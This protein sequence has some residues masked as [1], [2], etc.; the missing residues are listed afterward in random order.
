MA[1]YESLKSAIKQVVKTNGN[2]E[3]TGALLQQSLLAMINS[4]GNGYQFVGIANPATNPGTPDARSYYMAMENGIYTNF[5]ALSINNE[6]GLFVYDGEWRKIS[7]DIVTASKLEQ[8][9]AGIQPINNYGTINNA[10][11]NEDIT[12]VDSLL[13][14]K[15]RA[16]VNCMGYVILRKDKTF[17]QQVTTANT[18]Y[19]IRYDFNLGTANIEMPANCILKFNGGKLNGGTIVGDNTV[20]FSPVSKCF[21]LSTILSG[22]WLANTAHSTWFSFVDDCVLNENYT[23]V[24]GTD[25]T[26]ALKNILLF[27]NIVFETGKYFAK[28]YYSLMSGQTINGNNSVLKFQYNSIYDSAFF[29]QNVN[30]ISISNLTIVGWKTEG[31][32][33]TEQAHGFSFQTSENIILQNVSSLYFRGDGFYVG[34]TDNASVSKNIT[35]SNVVA[36]NNH[37]QG[38]SITAV[39]LMLVENSEFS[40]TSGTDPQAGIDIEP[41]PGEYCK[42]ITFDNIKCVNN[43]QSGLEF[44]G[45]H[46]AVSQ[47]VVRNYYY[48]EQTATGGSGISFWQASD[49]TIDGF[50]IKTK[51][52]NGIVLQDI[53]LSNIKL[54]HGKIIGDGQTASGLFY[55]SSHDNSQIEIADVE[56]YG[57]GNYGLQIPGNSV[58]DGLILRD[59]F[60]HNCYYNILVAGANVKNVNIQNV[61]QS[62]VG[63]TISGATYPGWSWGWE[64]GIQTDSKT[65]IDNDRTISGESSKRPTG[66]SDNY[67][68]FCFFDS[69]LGKP[70]WWNGSNWVDATGTTV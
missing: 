30:G 40:A 32:E 21:S 49:I 68:G 46:G 61:R 19:E 10:P 48:E 66:L 11:D 42:N 26:Q 33:E 20:V 29:A 43:N 16:P 3:V 24:S 27:S 4:L 17:A 63:K 45:Y 9:L 65:T 28:G 34:S 44:N 60:V 67:V 47:I 36:R 58:I 64:R 6:I 57:F 37:R 23:Y 5:G 70:I 12:T 2:N 35:M 41:N 13:K 56:I 15:D 53:P 54:L 55:A 52:R 14:L 38:L 25:N 8:A 39:D 22:T 62:N 69:T 1:N 18:I 31:T 51:N 50:T 59:I 7:T